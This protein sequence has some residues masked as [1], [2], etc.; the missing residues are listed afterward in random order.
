MTA[1]TLPTY[2]AARRED[3]VEDLHGHQ[4][5]DP[6]RWL[7]GADSADTQAWSASQDELYAGYRDGL[8]L[9]G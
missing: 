8:R 9:G 6:Y 1:R 7:E 4:V 2:P 5:A 3:L